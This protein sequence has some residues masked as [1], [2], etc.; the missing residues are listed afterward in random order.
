MLA[1]DQLGKGDAVAVMDTEL[2]SEVVGGSGGQLHDADPAS[3]VSHHQHCSVVVL[4]IEPEC[5]LGVF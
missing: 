4:R 1:V 3:S 5:I 2:E